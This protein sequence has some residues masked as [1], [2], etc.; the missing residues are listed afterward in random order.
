MAKKKSPLELR[1]L[2][3]KQAELRIRQRARLQKIYEER[4]LNTGD[5]PSKKDKYLEE[6]E[7]QKLIENE[8]LETE[9]T[10]SSELLEDKTSI[11]DKTLDT[12]P[13]TLNLQPADKKAEKKRIRAEKQAEKERIKREKE[14]EKEREKT[15]EEA[16]E[17]QALQEKERIVRE[18]LE[19]KERQQRE[20]EL[21]KER[22][23]AEKL[24]EKERLKQENIEARLE[25]ERLQQKKEHEI[26]NTF[27]DK[28]QE[29]ERIAVAKQEEKE[30]LSK[31]KE[32]EKIQ[33]EEQRE[34]EKLRKQAEREELKRAREEERIR[35]LHQEKEER[36][37]KRVQNE[38][39]RIARIEEKE[40]RK[41]EKQLQRLEKNNDPLTT[42]DQ[43]KKEQMYKKIT[44][45]AGLLL[46]AS[47]GYVA[48]LKTKDSDAE[49]TSQNEALKM[50]VDR[51]KQ[52]TD[53]LGSVNDMLIENLG[54]ET[55]GVFF[56]VQIGVYKHFKLD[57]YQENFTNFHEDK[58]D[59]LVK[60]TLARFRNFE[61]A[62][63]FEKDVK[64]LGIQDAFIVCKIDGERVSLEQA[65]RAISAAAR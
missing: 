64:A 2:R 49:L 28:F 11:P 40:R 38:A 50:M 41:A 25:K 17:L 7:A 35:Q 3:Q 10:D 27:R 20:E 52:Q 53:S 34:E 55:K 6:L 1:K 29:K 61:Q 19:E 59:K 51:L 30:R 56:E 18:K 23:K 57:R 13:D 39:V 15:E 45:A 36:E 32:A 26:E 37:R 14:A 47:L 8:N 43:Q 65:L 31:E 42:E 58:I 5:R 60:Y 24:A 33:K 12:E 54:K 9:F 63:Q 62:Q 44:I 48:F 22:I 46:I 4:G 16:R 21:E